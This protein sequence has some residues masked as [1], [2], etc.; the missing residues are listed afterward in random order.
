M[1]QQIITLLA[2]A[3]L[4]AGVAEAKVYTGTVY[5]AADGEPLIGATV[6]VKNGGIGV[7]TDIDGEFSIDIPEKAKT[8]VIR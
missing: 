4:T 5:S 6:A 8:L 2:A 7:S 1:K 3:A